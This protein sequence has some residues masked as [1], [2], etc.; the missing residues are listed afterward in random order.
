[1]KRFFKKMGIFM[2]VAVSFLLIAAT[3]IWFYPGLILNDRTAPF[4]NRYQN[5]SVSWNAI[6]LSGESRNFFVKHV[7]L[8]T[9]DL[10]VSHG[11]LNMCFDT[12]EVDSLYD[13]RHPRTIAIQRWTAN[14]TSASLKINDKQSVRLSLRTKTIEGERQALKITAESPPF[15]VHATWIATYEGSEIKISGPIEWVDR[16][17]TISK[18]VLEF[19]AVIKISSPLTIDAKWTHRESDTS[20]RAKLTSPMDLS[21][22]NFNL[23]LDVKNFKRLAQPLNYFRF[24]IP[25]PFAAFEG[26]V[27]VTAEGTATHA[28]TEANV[29]IKSDLFLE[30]QKLAFDVK[31]VFADHHSSRTQ[32]DITLRDILLQLPNLDYRQ[33]S[34]LKVDRRIRVGKPEDKSKIKK[35]AANFPIRLN[36]ITG[37][38]PVRLKLRESADLIPIRFSY[39][40]STLEKIE[41]LSA[42]IEPFDFRAFKQTAHLEFLKLTKQKLGSPI[43]LSGRIRYRT[44]ELDIRI[45][46]AGTTDKP[47]VHF[48]S[49]PPL[50]DDQILAVLLFGRPLSSLDPDEQTSLGNISPALTKGAFGLAS[51]YLFASTPIE[52]VGYDPEAE[53]YTVKFRLG[54][55]MTFS[56]GTNV[57]G[58]Q[59]LTFRKRL[60]SHWAIE[61][62]WTRQSSDQT[63]RLSTFLEW[64]TRY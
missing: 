42:E 45:I 39:Q 7:R 34:H 40:L 18:S 15:V 22:T 54:H 41:R 59:E 55:R 57:K 26:A 8:S 25:A 28:G 37:D 36:V 60:G 49:E 32:F 6:H 4:L 62:Q 48:E 44:S 43:D 58:N 33:L 5:E 50:R 23:S 17:Q 52:Y 24:S 16:K 64:F 3:V 30:N 31:G 29:Q 63:S 56:V 13:L 12:F 20:L 11:K 53:A 38:K 10:C 2:L 27:S 47:R 9:K 19:D 61:S 51:L 1:M 21:K 35:I 46:L 14:T